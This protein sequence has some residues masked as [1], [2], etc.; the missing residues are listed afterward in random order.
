MCGGGRG[1]SGV[2]GGDGQGGSGAGGGGTT[3]MFLYTNGTSSY[4]IWLHIT[5]GH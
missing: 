1:G 2:R 3:R 4:V 5:D